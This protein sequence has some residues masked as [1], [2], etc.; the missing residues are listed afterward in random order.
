MVH[1]GNLTRAF[2]YSIGDDSI[3]SVSGEDLLIVVSVLGFLST[4]LASLGCNT[5]GAGLIHDWTRITMTYAEM[6]ILIELLP[7]T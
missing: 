2:S 7:K 4:F 1:D 6:R 5:S 3:F